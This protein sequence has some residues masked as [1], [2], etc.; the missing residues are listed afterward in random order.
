MSK[1][2]SAWK[3]K[4]NPGLRVARCCVNCVYCD[5]QHLYYCGVSPASNKRN[6][7]RA[8][9]NV[10]DNWKVADWAKGVYG[11]RLQGKES[12]R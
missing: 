11:G 7:W 2:S 5:R 9:I 6:H 10:C 4:H 8:G 3:K 12:N 1:E